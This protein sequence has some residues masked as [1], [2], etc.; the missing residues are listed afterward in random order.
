MSGDL[1]QSY[2]GLISIQ[3]LW[4]LA[5]LSFLVA[6]LA[7]RAMASLS[8]LR[9]DID[10]AQAE[11]LARSVATVI[12]TDCQSTDSIDCNYG[13]NCFDWPDT[14]AISLESDTFEVI[15]SPGSYPSFWESGSAGDEESRININSAPDFV[16]HSVFPGGWQVR[17]ILEYRAAALHTATDS[18][19]FWPVLE[20]TVGVGAFRELDDLLMMESITPENLHDKRLLLTTRGR[21]A[22][23]L[24]TVGEEILTLT[25]CPVS[26]RARLNSARAL[27]RPKDNPPTVIIFRSL[28]QLIAELI[29]AGNV[30]S[31]EEA[32]YLKDMINYRLLGVVSEN[33]SYCLRV[34]KVNGREG[35]TLGETLCRP[36]DDSVRVVSVVLWE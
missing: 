4:I 35:C 22:L 26:L 21:G 24:N 18:S 33:F 19:G 11:L 3:A 5:V 32:N 14:L 12:R 10:R 31:P 15:I 7:L 34:R 23:N 16:L 36:V 25:G 9:R 29:R 20:D 2:G 30:I 28:G 27:W 1:R 17:E 8:V 13:G 6:G